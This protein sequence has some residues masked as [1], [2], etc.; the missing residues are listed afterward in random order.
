MSVYVYIYIYKLLWC[1]PR[2]QGQLLRSLTV[3]IIRHVSAWAVEP[4]CDSEEPIALSVFTHTFE[5]S[6]Q[7]PYTS[8]G[9]TVTLLRP[10]PPYTKMGNNLNGSCGSGQ[11]CQLGSKLERIQLETSTKRGGETPMP[12]GV[13][14]LLAADRWVLS[15]HLLRGCPKPQPAPN[16]GKGL[17]RPLRLAQFKPITCMEEG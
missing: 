16:L 15:Q 1:S 9:S 11:I 13:D 3:S 12:L 10:H 17:R 4:S 2:S 7:T 6:S 14:R 8:S 5:P